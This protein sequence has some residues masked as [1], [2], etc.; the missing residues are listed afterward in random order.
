[1]FLNDPEARAFVR[2]D[3]ALYERIVSGGVRL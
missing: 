2:L 3:R 1:M